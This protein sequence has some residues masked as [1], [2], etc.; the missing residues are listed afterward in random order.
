M[1]SWLQGTGPNAVV[2]RCLSRRVTTDCTLRCNDQA[3]PSQPPAGSGR[4]PDTSSEKTSWECDTGLSAVSPIVSSEFQVA[5]IGSS[6]LLS[7]S[8]AIRWISSNTRSM[9]ARV[10]RWE[11]MENLITVWFLTEL[12]IT[13]AT[14][15]A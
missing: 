15:L 10:V 14:P 1:I 2:K 7:I 5:R 9:S 3:D 8:R 4:A 11:Q 12:V 13:K 6:F